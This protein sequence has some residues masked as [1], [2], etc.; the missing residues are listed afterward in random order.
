M[1]CNLMSANFPA[2]FTWGTATASYQIEGAFDTDGRGA[3]I[4][5]TFSKTP[6][7]VVNG[8]TGDIACDHYNRFEEDIA[9]M[10]ELGVSAYRFSIAWPRL[11]PKGD[12]NREERGF[13]FYNRLIDALI[14]AGIEPMVTLYHW[15]LPQTLE[16]KG[17]WAN[18]G[19]VDAFADYATACAEAFGDR[20]N[21]WITLNEPWCVSWLGYSNG[22]H[23]PGKKD[24]NLAIAASHHTALAHAAAFRAIKKVRPEAKVGLTVNMNNIHNESPENQEVADFAALNDSNL[25]RWWIDALTTG[26]YPKNLIDT[27]GDRTAGII[28]DGDEKLLVTD[29]DF[30][31]I[32]YYCDGFVRAPRPEDKPA[33]EGGFMPFPQRADSSAP[34]HLA[35]DLTAMGWVVTPEGLGNLVKRVHKDWPQIPYLVITEN[36]SSYDD[37]KENGQVIDTKRT[38]YL[39]AH[40]ESLQ[41]AIADGAPVKGYFAWSLLD[42]YEWAEG[43]AKRFGIVHVDFQTQERTP[44]MSFAKYKEIIAAN[45]VS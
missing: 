44:K 16:D 17:G 42:N 28:L 38:A 18:R 26:K 6:G 15:D 3:S 33:I 31:G 12:S 23:A 24:Y 4:W 11:F 43:Y 36:G 13:A 45:A 41:S 29:V 9:I 39:V 37:V 25:N 2:E 40:L 32:N 21:N 8:D 27:Y 20:I 34:A 22:V 35:Q 10:K 14:A 19:V 5:D 7:K 30:M 1:G